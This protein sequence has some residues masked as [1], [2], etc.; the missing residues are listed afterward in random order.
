MIAACH[1]QK[2]HARQDSMLTLSACSRNMHGKTQ[3]RRGSQSLFAYCAGDKP[4][5]AFP[6]RKAEEQH[7]MTW[8]EALLQRLQ[9]VPN[10][11]KYLSLELVARVH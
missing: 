8:S 6:G 7:G 9:H 1:F 10:L 11:H 4:P 2:V 5:A 3:N